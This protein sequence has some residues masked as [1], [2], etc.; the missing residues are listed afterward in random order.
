MATGTV[1]FTAANGDMLTIAQSSVSM[2][3][4]P[5]SNSFTGIAVI[6]GESG[7]FAN[8][9][10][11]LSLHGTLTFD[12]GGIGHALSNIHGADRLRC[13]RSERVAGHR[14][15]REPS[16]EGGAEAPPSRH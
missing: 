14:A 11:S 7:R 2:D 12:Q 15:R 10:E 9:R 8:A 13:L 6:T 3:I 4:G 1:T 5:M 16:R